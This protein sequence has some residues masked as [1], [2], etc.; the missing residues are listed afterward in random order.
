MLN[1]HLGLRT[2]PVKTIKYTSERLEEAT[3]KRLIATDQSLSATENPWFRQMM[4]IASRVPDGINMLSR[5]MV[6]ASIIRMFKANLLKLKALLNSSN[7]PGEVHI[8]CDAWQADNLD[9]YFVATGSFTEVT[10]GVWRKRT[11]MLGFGRLQNARN[12]K[13]LGQSLFII[14]ARLGF[15]HKVGKVNCNNSSNNGTMMV[16]FAFPIGECT[17]LFRET[18]RLALS[19]CDSLAP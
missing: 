2:E 17:N 3:N 5:K 1:G 7:F 6:Q 12:G 15:T 16:E 8:A 11:V 10:G 13:R 9:A 4:E 14:V 19:T 18:S